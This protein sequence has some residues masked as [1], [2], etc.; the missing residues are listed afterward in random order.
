MTLP[1]IGDGSGEE[2]TDS[3]SLRSEPR[4]LRRVLVAQVLVKRGTRRC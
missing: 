3:V 4:G 2:W 1:L